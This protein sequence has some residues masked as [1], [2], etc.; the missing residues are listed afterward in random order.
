VLGLSAQDAGDAYNANPSRA[1]LDRANG[2]AT[3][4]TVAWVTGGVL[5]A[6]GITF[7]L[8]PDKAPSKDPDKKPNLEA[9]PT[10]PALGFSPSLGGAVL[11]GTF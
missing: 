9:P 3:W 5:L 10:E 1:A 2:L 7:V 8:L 4:A 6:A 11:R